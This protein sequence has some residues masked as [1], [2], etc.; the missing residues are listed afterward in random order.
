MWLP[1]TD[2]VVVVTCNPVTEAEAAAYLAVNPPPS[3]EEERTRNKA[4]LEPMCKLL[5]EGLKRKV[6]ATC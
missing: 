2:S 5:K 1:Y 3:P 6:N 4:A